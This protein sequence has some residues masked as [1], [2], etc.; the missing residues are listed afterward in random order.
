[1]LVP[2]LPPV[3]CAFPWANDEAVFTVVARSTWP[4]LMRRSCHGLRIH[5]G[6]VDEAVV[7]MVV[8]YMADVDE[9]VMLCV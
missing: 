1:M 4:T 5:M 2:Q 7:I 6:D 8:D 3:S 9:A